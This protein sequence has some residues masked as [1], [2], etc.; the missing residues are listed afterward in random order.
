MIQELF[1]V[2]DNESENILLILIYMNY[3]STIQDGKLMS[4]IL[5][6]EECPA[7]V[8]RWLW[9][10]ITSADNENN[11]AHQH[12]FEHIEHCP[13]YITRTVSSKSNNDI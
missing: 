5:T 9:D 1:R 8:K 12:P 7:F 4:E 3:D 13:P 2:H 10:T 11:D 6:N